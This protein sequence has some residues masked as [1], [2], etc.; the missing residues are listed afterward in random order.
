M[1]KIKYKGEKY[2][3]NAQLLEEAIKAGENPVKAYGRI[4]KSLV[5]HQGL[6]QWL[7]VRNLQLE[8]TYILKP[9][10]LDKTQ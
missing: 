4:Y 2:E 9:K 3:L 6:N 7:K 8:K 1:K 5:P 10:K